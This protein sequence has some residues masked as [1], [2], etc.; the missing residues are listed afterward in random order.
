LRRLVPGRRFD[1]R[2]NPIF[3]AKLAFET[4]TQDRDLG[5]Y[6]STVG[7]PHW[8]IPTISSVRREVLSHAG[9]VRNQRDHARPSCNRQQFERDT[10]E[11]ERPQMACPTKG[12][13]D[14]RVGLRL[15]TCRSQFRSI[16]AS[17]E[18]VA[19]GTLKSASCT[20]RTLSSSC[21]AF[22]NARRTTRFV[23][24]RLSWR[25]FCPLAGSG[26]HLHCELDLSILLFIRSQR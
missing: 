20:V 1:T 7:S 22:P 18:T 25:T 15:L 19:S 14:E 12:R 5:R 24:K 16:R 21:T 17:K 4:G 10:T 3:A 2:C 9:G 11:H 8:A 13:G 26:V 6:V 23:W